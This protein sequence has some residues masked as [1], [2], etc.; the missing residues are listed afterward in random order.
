[1]VIDLHKH[2]TVYYRVW[3]LQLWSQTAA[4]GKIKKCVFYAFLL[5]VSS[6]SFSLC[7][8]AQ[9]WAALKAFSISSCK[10]C[11]N[12][13][14]FGGKY[15][16]QISDYLGEE[17]IW[18]LLVYKSMLECG[19]LAGWKGH[20]SFHCE[21][22]CDRGTVWGPWRLKHSLCLQASWEFGS[23]CWKSTWETGE[24]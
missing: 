4:F 22:S 5:A 16:S 6:A 23:N 9:R 19:E 11:Y 17:I 7:N 1:M 15:Q 21:F 13:K 12:S 18:W 8:F 2:F 14:T 24:S 3:H 20:F 10:I